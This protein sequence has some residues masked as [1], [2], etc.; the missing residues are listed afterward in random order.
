MKNIFKLT[1]LAVFL[2]CLVSCDD[3][4]PIIPTLEVTP[5]NLNGTWEL[6]EWNGTPLAEGTYCY[7]TFNRKEQ[8][9]EM[10]QKFDSMYARYITGSFSI[11][12]DPYLGAVIS[13]EYDFGNGEWNNKYIV[14]DLLESGSMIWTAKQIHTLRESTGKHYCG[15]KSGQ[16]RVKQIFQFF[17]HKFSL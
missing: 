14:T 8:T 17:F 5:A 2:C 15:S 13:G 9:F 3:D 12:N 16:G 6:S 11:K 1:A 7:I 4:E 10:Y